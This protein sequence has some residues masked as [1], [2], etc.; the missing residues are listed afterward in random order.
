[1]QKKF[2]VTTSIPYVNAKPHVGFAMEAIQADVLAR[3]HRMK[4]EDVFC[5]TGSDE[6]GTKLAQ[7]AKDMNTTPKEFADTISA[8]F[9]EL[10]GTL[11]LDYDGFIRTTDDIHI[12]GAQKMWSKL[13]EAGDLYKSG[14][15]GFY[16]VGCEGFVLEKDL[17]DGLCP[18][19]KKEP[20]KLKEENYFFAL[21][22]Y[23]DRIA[24]VIE[25]DEVRIVPESRKHEI[26]SVIKEGLKDVSF[27]RPKKVLDWGIDV[28]GDPDHVMYVWCDALSNYIT[29]LG[30]EDESDLYRR[31]WPADAQIIGK[32]ILRF[33]AAIW[34]GMLMSAGLPLPK[35]ICVHGFITS[36]GMKM[37]KSLN[38]VVDPAEF[39]NRYGT[40]ALRY[41]LMKEIPTTDDGDFSKERFKI[42][43]ES[44]LAN[45]IGNLVSRVLAMTAKYFD[46][47]VP[48]N[49]MENLILKEKAVEI[50]TGYVRAI[51]DFDLKKALE[52][53][54]DFAYFAN[55][56]VDDTKPWVLAKNEDNTELKQVIYN[57]L[58]MIRHISLLL[59]PFMPETSSKISGWLGGN[60]EPFDFEKAI[61]WAGLVPGTQVEKAIPL[62]ARVED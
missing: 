48:E 35:S 16:C 51:E 21:S 58:E 44:E 8:A 17:V 30:Y 42:V 11:N 28:P 13:A 57:L 3:F 29:A 19:H 20:Q 38:N 60:N 37:S 62:F 56:Y 15:E 39:V 18:N 9:R 32:D 31:Y 27:S 59:K 23:N 46:G 34:I 55:K 25:S 26:L 40:D 2:Y 7:C 53:V 61:V 12:R 5:L 33:H 52:V 24:K 43:Y 41:F 22:K 50:W 14:Y 54:A 1:M 49:G 36:E 10:K 47:K 6:H 4:G 45:S